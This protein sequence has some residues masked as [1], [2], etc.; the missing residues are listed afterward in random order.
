M[1]RSTLSSPF[2]KPQPP[3]LMPNNLF[4]RKCI[5]CAYLHRR[6]VFLTPHTHGDLVGVKYP[7]KF[8]FAKNCMKCADLHRKIMLPSCTKFL[9]PQHT[10]KGWGF[11]NMIF[12]YISAYFVK[13]LAKLFS[14]LDPTP[15]PPWGWRIR[16][17]IFCADLHISCNSWQKIALV[18]YPTSHGGGRLETWFF[19]PYLHISFNS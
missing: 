16:N 19:F 2:S 12:L 3:W 6:I 13:F 8:I 7:K 4:A 11:R 14:V 17:K 15:L 9:S 10:P 1:C 5:K 18:L